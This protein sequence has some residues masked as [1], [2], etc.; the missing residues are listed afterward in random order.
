M[1]I[2]AALAPKRRHHLADEGGSRLRPPGRHPARMAGDAQRADPEHPRHQRLHAVR[3]SHSRDPLSPR[4]A[5]QPAPRA[6]ASST[7]GSASSTSNI[8]TCSTTSSPAGT[9]SPGSAAVLRGHAG[10]R[11]PVGDHDGVTRRSDGPNWKHSQGGLNPIARVRQG[12]QPRCCSAP[13]GATRWELATGLGTTEIGHFG[14]RQRDARRAA[15]SQG[16]RRS[17]PG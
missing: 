9:T 15:S 14:L 8:S 13:K 16:P 3:R 11:P 7:Q 10:R 2:R 17:T 1:R 5:R 6:S 12:R 4:A